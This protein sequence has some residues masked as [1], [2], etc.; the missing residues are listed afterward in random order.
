M[1]PR[2]RPSATHLPPQQTSRG[3][4]SHEPVGPQQPPS[5]QTPSHSVFPSA[6]HTPTRAS[7]QRNPRAQHP[8]PQ[9]GMP[10]GQ[11]FQL[12]G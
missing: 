11:Q 4:R 1:T 8:G 6:Q 3:R 10:F 12:R 2:Q 7:A 5:T 9:H